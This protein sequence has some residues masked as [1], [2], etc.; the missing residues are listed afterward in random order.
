MLC[1]HCGKHDARYH[2]KQVVNG[3]VKEVHLCEYCVPIFQNQGY[4]EPMIDIQS[5]FGNFHLAG[6]GVGDVFKELFGETTR[7]APQ[8]SVR[9]HP[10][11]GCGMRLQDFEKTGRL[12]CDECYSHF[13]EAMPSLLQ[14]LHGRA[15]HVGKVP[16][17]GEKHAEEKSE[18]ILLKEQL[19]KAIQEENFEMACQLRDQ[20]KAAE[21]EKLEG[22]QDA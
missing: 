1:E 2:V 18:M 8:K 19:Q 12:G 20:I 4:F 9:Q 11:P 6:T 3:Q 7:N 22:D 13:A 16:V 5:F 15:N 10:C 17:S 21:A 14:R